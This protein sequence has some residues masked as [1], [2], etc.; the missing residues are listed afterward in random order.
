[1]RDPQEREERP[2]GGAQLNNETNR[3]AKDSTEGAPPV[4]LGSKAFGAGAPDAPEGGASLAPVYCIAHARNQRA[5]RFLLQ[6]AM[7]DLADQELEARVWG[8]R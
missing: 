3:H 4:C 7:E 8:D 1:M 5:R 6:L 2:G